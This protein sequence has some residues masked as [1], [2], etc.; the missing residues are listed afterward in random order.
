[1][2]ELLLA[3]AVQTRIVKVY[4]LVQAGWAILL[5]DNESKLDF[6]SCML[7]S[8]E[9]KV[10]RPQS[11]GARDGAPLLLRS[12]LGSAPPGGRRTP[13]RGTVPRTAGL[14]S[15]ELERGPPEQSRRPR[16]AMDVRGP[17]SFSLSQPPLPRPG[18]GMRARPK[19][20]LLQ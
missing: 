6:L 12:R 2:E 4:A 16:S 7:R 18:S 5:L 20:P 1:M 17:S 3:E 15:P 13:S 10:R 14:H 19:S 11:G 8:Q 9:P